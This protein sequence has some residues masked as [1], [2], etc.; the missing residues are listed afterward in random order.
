V[1]AL[2]A[3]LS[4]HPLIARVLSTR[5]IGDPDKAREFLNPSLD[6]LRDPFLMLD[7]DVAV[8][9]IINALRD[10]ERILVHGDFDT[11]GLTST[12][13]LVQTLKSLGGEVDYF[14]P[15]RLEEGYG[16]GKAG[17]DFARDA[18]AN[19][20]VTCDCGVTSVDPVRYASSLGID[21][22]ITDHHQPEEELPPAVAVVNPHRSDCTYP[23]KELAGVG[24]VSKLVIALLQR[25]GEEPQFPSILRMCAIGTIAD[26][27]PLI[28]ENRIFAHHGLS[29]LPGTPNLGLR[30]LIDVAG[31]SNSTIS[32]YDVSFR[33]A[34]RINS[35][36]RF[37]RQDIAMDLFFTKSRSDAARIAS[38]MDRLNVKRQRMVERMVEQATETIEAS[39]DLL[40]EKI[41]VIG[42]KRWHKGVVGI[43]ASKLVESYNRPS[44]AI[45]IEDEIGIGSG[46]SLADFNIID[47]LATC[48][49]MLTRYGGH[50]MA[51]G[52][53]L[54]AGSIPKFRD[55][56]SAVAGK[57][58][59][60]DTMLPIID[61]DSEMRFSEVDD[62]FEEQLAK[63][64]PT[65]Y[66]NS[67]PV[68]LARGVQV[69]GNPRI[70]KEKHV[71]MRLKQDRKELSAIAWRKAKELQHLS[72][73]DELDIIFSCFFNTW[74][75]ERKL[76]L[77]LIAYKN[78]DGKDE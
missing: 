1:D 67:N 36:G 3:D 60:E 61:V 76:E 63:L 44:L 19:L 59:R 53:E 14:I 20:L 22:V 49:E 68:F 71:K 2:Q 43:L 64:E 58:I 16:L 48:D 17:V 29:L 15:N 50:A 66:G 56:L 5:G 55:K 27:V 7:M 46:R 72:G 25:C 37:G 65:G 32:S 9:R 24:V 34:P 28:D 75:E 74:R 8:D 54:P 45:A 31:L 6:D 73:G 30:A 23:F 35:M 33:I 47:A 38:T 41:I 62:Q 77:E 4:V 12:A 39:P 18:G 11:D 40:R 42:D 51:A 26:V 57:E 69:F 70:L 78:S 13:L 52:F 21:T 10:N